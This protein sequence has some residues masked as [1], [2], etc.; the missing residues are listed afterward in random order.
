VKRAT[1]LAAVL[2]GGALLGFGAATPASAAPAGGF[3]NYLVGAMA[4]VYQ[5]TEDAPNA[6][7]HPQGEGEFVYSLATMSKATAYALS[8]LAWPGGAAGNA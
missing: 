1:G 5:M 8:A 4:P 6:T 3:Q 7:F 2:L